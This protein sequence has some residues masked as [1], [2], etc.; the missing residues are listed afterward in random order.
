[1]TTKPE[2]LLVVD[3]K[4]RVR[5]ETVKLT[6]RQIDAAKFLGMSKGRYAEWV[7]R[8]KQPNWLGPRFEKVGR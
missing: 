8:A 2:V 6:D 3:E 4:G 7:W 5:K 1:M